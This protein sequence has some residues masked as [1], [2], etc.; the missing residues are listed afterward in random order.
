MMRQQIAR[1]RPGQRLD[2]DVGD[3]EQQP[4]G[5]RQQRPAGAPDGARRFRR[6]AAAP[7]SPPRRPRRRSS[8]RSSSWRCS[9]PASTEVTARSARPTAHRPRPSHS[10]GP[11]RTPNQRW[12]SQASSTRPPEMVVSTSEI[13]ATASAATCR[14]RRRSRSRSRSSTIASETAPPR[15]EAAGSAAPR[16]PPRRRG[17][18][19]ASP[20]WWPGRRRAPAVCRVEP[21]VNGSASTPNRLEESATVMDVI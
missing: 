3:P 1:N 7:R 8:R 10:R 6:A 9:A 21:S 20:R 5:N 12:A 19:R 2:R 18:C 16:A 17:T 4:G 13:G 14:P 15:S 11:T